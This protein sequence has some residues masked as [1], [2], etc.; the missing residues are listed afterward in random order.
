MKRF[1]T[2]ILLTTI[3]IACHIETPQRPLARFTYTPGN[4]CK[5]PCKVT[6]KSEAENAE[7]I[8]WD[9]GDGSTF[10]SG[11]SVEHTFEIAKSYQVKMIARGV[12]GGSS[13][14]TQTVTIEAPS[15]EAFSLSGDYNFPTDIIADAQGNVYI[16]GT[17][18][19]IINFSVEK[20]VDLSKGMDDFFVAKYD[21]AG[22]CLWVYTDG[23]SGNDHANAL[24][25]DN[26]GF[27]YVTGF[28]SGEVASGGTSTKGGFDG[29][30]AK[31]SATDGKPKWFATFGGPLN[32]QGRSLAFYH[33]AEGMKLYLTGTVEGDKQN[34]NI[35]FANY[36]KSAENRDGFLVVL[37]A[38]LG[39]FGEPM[40][41]TGPNI[42]APEAI[43]I[44][45]LGNA[46]ITGAFLDTIKTS[47]FSYAS[48][49]TVDVFV[50]K[51]RRIGPTFHWEWLRRAGSKGIDFAYDIIVDDNS[52]N[53]YV[54][55][56]HTGYLNELKLNSNDDENVYLGNW[57]Y[58]GEVQNNAKNGFSAGQDYHGGIALAPNGDIVL[59]GSFNVKGAFPMNSAASI[60]SKGSTDIFIT[61]V[62]P[63][64]LNPIIQTPLTDGGNNEDRVNKICVI[65]GYVYAAG[66][67]HESSTFN[68]VTLYGESL[69]IRNT[70]IARYKL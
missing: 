7:S 43:A 34:N 47:S 62:D 22:H 66:W 14:F 21:S 59:A 60:R 5:A 36:R 25:M 13:G 16:S 42:Q 68:G 9:F 48:Q 57:N 44:D 1:F 2:Y 11:D 37:D 27:V 31:L 39:T 24:A 32:D 49:D 10:K 40:M 26:S 53:V 18:S 33:A 23:S 65:N 64:G 38:V 51:L 61:K 30:V 4:G 55:G 28:V 12:D 15:P 3:A 29:F 56:M 17:G 67:F 52:Q 8:Q 54:T 35:E 45:E 58:K 63:K 46:Y 6:F 50:A 41:I 20:S 19:D 69:P 70:F